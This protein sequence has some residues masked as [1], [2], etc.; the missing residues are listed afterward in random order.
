MRAKA[1]GRCMGSQ[2]LLCCFLSSSTFIPMSFHATCMEPR[3]AASQ[4]AIS[5]LQVL[6]I[7][8][9]G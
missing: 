8:A 3:G 9:E 7:S 1:W 2:W 4:D 6:L 5:S